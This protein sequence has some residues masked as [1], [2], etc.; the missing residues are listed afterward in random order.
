VPASNWTL[1]EAYSAAISAVVLLFGVYL[2]QRYGRRAVPSLV[3]RTF[4]RGETGIGLE[5]RIEIKSVGLK[6]LR[7]RKGR[8]GDS[9][10]PTL[11][12]LEVVDSGATYEFR[13]TDSRV[14][15]ILEG[16][17]A[18]PG[19]IIRRSELFYLREPTP[20]VVGW[21][22]EFDLDMQHP[23]RRRKWWSW[24][25]DAFIPAGGVPDLEDVYTEEPDGNPD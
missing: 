14:V 19:E 13:E 8:G 21:R 4:P 25:E 1:V 12:I 23:I 2:A 15:R 20:D 3:A 5:A 7:V 22:V 11:T 18:G 9:H 24:Q 6:M 17:V 10:R 16:Q